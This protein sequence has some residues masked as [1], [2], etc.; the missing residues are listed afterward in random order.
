MQE[1]KIGGGHYVCKKCGITVFGTAI[2]KCKKRH[3]MTQREIIT[4]FRT[5]CWKQSHQ[6][7]VSVNHNCCI[8]AE[9][10]FAKWIQRLQKRIKK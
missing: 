8:C 2:H 1:I 9:K 3:E 5:W 7:C 4:K 10:Y 6:Y